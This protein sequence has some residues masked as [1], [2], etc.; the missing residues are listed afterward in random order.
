LNEEVWELAD[1]I[2]GKLGE[3]LDELDAEFDESLNRLTSYT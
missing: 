2:E 1:A 3:E